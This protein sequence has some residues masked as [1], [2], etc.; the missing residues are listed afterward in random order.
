[1]IRASFP[2]RSIQNQQGDVTALNYPWSFAGKMNEVDMKRAHS[3]TFYP[4]SNHAGRFM[5][6][7]HK[8]RMARR[9]KSGE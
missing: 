8:R 3:L 6:I 1:M 4:Y 5:H 2:L 9:C 7:S